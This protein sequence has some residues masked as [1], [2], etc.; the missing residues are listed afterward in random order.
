MKQDS[1][2][3]FYTATIMIAKSSI[4]GHSMTEKAKLEVRQDQLNVE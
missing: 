1:H 2:A 3:H 4:A